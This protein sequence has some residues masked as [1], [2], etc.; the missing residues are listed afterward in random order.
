[1][2]R[3]YLCYTDTRCTKRTPVPASVYYATMYAPHHA[4][5]H[6]EKQSN[7]EAVPEKFKTT[8]TSTICMRKIFK[9]EK[10]RKMVD[11]KIFLSNY[12]GASKSNV[13]S[14][15]FPYKRIGKKFFFI[16]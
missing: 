15:L 3:Y 13:A 14:I 7:D 5:V 4:N 1:M 9:N 6:Y 10:Q 16:E 12:L 8:A 11:K 2:N